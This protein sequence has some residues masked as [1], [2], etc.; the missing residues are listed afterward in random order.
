M[1]IAPLPPDEV[2]RIRL[3]HALNVLDSDPEPEFDRIT[4]LVSHLLKVPM[5]LISLVDS[6]RQWF[7]SRVGVTD[8]ETSRDLS[9]CAH[10]IL[11][12]Q[13]MVVEDATRDERFADHPM[14]TGGPRV[15]FYAGVPIRS[16]GGLA[17][18][19]LCAIDSHPRQLSAEQLEVLQDLADIA[20]KEMQLRETVSLAQKQLSRTDNVLEASEARFRAVFER[21]AVGV[22]T[23]AP[24][25]GWLSMNDAVCEIT[26]YSREE[27]QRLTFQ[28]ITHPDDLKSDLKALRKLIAGD[29]DRYQIEKRYLRKGGGTVWVNLNVTKKQSP[30]GELEYFISTLTD[31]QARK[32][33]EAALEGLRLELEKRVEERTRQ[34]NK[35][36]LELRSVIENANDAY[37]SID[38]TGA[39][40]GWNRQ[41]EATFG[42]RAEEAL[43]QSL[44]DLIVPPELRE[45][46]RL[47][48]LHYLA[49]G[50]SKVVDQRL[51]LPALRRDGSSLH[52][53]VRIR[54][55]NLDGQRVFSAFLHDITDR[56]KAQA[57]RE[58]EALMDPLTGLLNRRALTEMLPG[59]MERAGRRGSALAVLFLDLDGF[60]AVNDTFG[61]DTGDLL[62][63]EVAARLRRVARG[64]DTLVRL[65]GDE[66]TVVLEGLT[67]D[68]DQA[69]KCAERILHAITQ[70]IHINTHTAQVGV[71]I[72]LAIHEPHTNQSADV[73][74]K[75]ADSAMYEAKHA[76][77]G[78]IRL[79]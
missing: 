59:A 66:F 37:I 47:G 40:T 52:V 12:T 4:R 46:H 42:W 31:I 20:S 43:G 24:G 41:A 56:R 14:V 34:L 74:M 15:R 78:C 49:T 54:A 64:S 33:A 65:A 50:E 79:S 44:H 57:L 1:L 13:P 68:S 26:G 72:G 35:R 45:A 16:V 28:D 62:L 69:M 27:L 36:E 71:S 5:A 30:G 55:L 21:A 70:P 2:E 11:G 51:E 8:S 18:G 10:A 22:A 75:R 7:K 58:R 63:R 39:V 3:L 23:I 29:I 48:M 38:A 61:H 77:K 73:L 17:L 53:E 19:T 76:G 60:K 32:E 25:G 9:F 6:E 67:S